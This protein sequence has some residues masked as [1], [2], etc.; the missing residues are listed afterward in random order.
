MLKLLEAN[1]QEIGGAGVQV[2]SYKAPVDRVGRPYH[3]H[4]FASL[5]PPAC[6]PTIKR[7]WRLNV[8]L[9]AVMGSTRA[10]IVSQQQAWATA[11]GLT[12]DASG[13]LST[14]EA[15]FFA[16]ISRHTRLE[17]T[18]VIRRVDSW[19]QRLHTRHPY[20]LNAN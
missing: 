4:W 15:N 12:H 18:D 13:Y 5:M 11:S 8:G 10:A 2:T 19:K 17:A 7:V 14:Y 16:A 6:E 3:A 20:G 9:G 1:P